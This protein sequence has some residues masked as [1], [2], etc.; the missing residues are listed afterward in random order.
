MCYFIRELFVFYLC[1]ILFKNNTLVYTVDNLIWWHHTLKQTSTILWKWIRKA[2]NTRL[3][4]RKE[5]K[6]NSISISIFK[7]HRIPSPVVRLPKIDYGT[8]YN[9]NNKQCFAQTAGLFRR[10]LCFVSTVHSLPSA[11]QCRV[12]WKQTHKQTKQFKEIKSVNHPKTCMLRISHLDWR[13]TV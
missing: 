3:Y 8:E 13:E 6:S 9:D 12:C 2:I 7:R 4:I 11:A 1:I 10:L 5:K